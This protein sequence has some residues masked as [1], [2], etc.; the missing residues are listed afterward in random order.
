MPC[1][2]AIL[3][4]LLLA[5]SLL[6]MAVCINKSRDSD[7][8][9]FYAIAAWPVMF[10]AGWVFLTGVLGWHLS[11]SLNR[12]SENIRVEA[13]VVSELK[14]RDVQRHILAAYVMPFPRQGTLTK[15]LE[16]PREPTALAG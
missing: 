9:I 6:L 3:S 16:A 8:A 10:A 13:I 14:F 12:R 15:E 2:A 1:F 7:Y 4:F 5:I 11:A